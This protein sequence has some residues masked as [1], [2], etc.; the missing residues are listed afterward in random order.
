MKTLFIAVIGINLAYGQITGKI[1]TSK[2]EPVS[3]ANVI[4]FRAA[5]SSLVAGV[6]A[7]ESGVFSLTS[8]EVGRFFLKV[9]SI[10]FREFRSEVFH[11]SSLSEVL[12]LPPLFL[13]EENNTIDEVRVAAKRDFIQ[14]TPLGKIINIQS[15]LMT[16]GSNALQ[17]LERLPGVITDRRNNQF[18]LNGQSGVTVL[19]NGRRVQLSSEELMTLLE[20]TVADNIE[21]IELIT[22]PGAQYDADGGAG[23]INIIFKNNEVLGT[24]LRL[25]ATAGYGFRE[26]AVT[27]VGFSQR[28]K[29]WNLNASYSFNHDVR[30]SGYEGDGTAGSSFMLGETYNTFYGMSRSFQNTHNATVTLQYQPNSRTTLGGDVVSSFGQ[31]HNLVNNGGSYQPKNNDFFEIAM[32]SDGT[33]AKYNSI[34]SIYYRYTLAPKTQ[35]HADVTYINYANDSPAQITTAYFDKQKQPAA[36][37]FPIFTAGNR[38]ESKSNIHVGVFKTDLTLPLSAKVNA[39]FGV[40]MSYAQNAN[41]S[42]VERKTEDRWEID[43]RSQSRIQSRERIAA[44]YAQFRLQLNPKASLQAGVRYEYWQ[45]DFTDNKDRFRISKLF[46]SL[47]YTLTINESSTLSF[48]YNRRIS[49]PAYTDL[50][51]N[52]F[53]TDPTFIFSGNP[54]LKPTLTDVVKADYTTGGMN[55]GLS[56]QYDLHPILRYQITANET[57]DVGISSPQNLDEMKS[58]NLFLSYPLQIVKGWKVSLNTTTSFRH[59]R[60]SYS[61][62]PTEKQFLFQNLNFSQTLQFPRNFEAELSGWYNFPFF[63]GPNQLKGFGVVNLGIAKKLKN[64]KGT[65]QLALPDLLRSFSVFTHNGGMTPIAFDINTVSNWRDETVFYRVVKLTYSRTFGKNTRGVQYE[66]KDEERE[67]VR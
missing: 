19:F 55:I 36:P 56:W 11:I 31:S 25:S 9:S 53:Y 16:K 23:I 62:F 32:L 29:R 22:S 12:T 27:S 8:S 21:K 48:N 14:T 41:D 26:K 7:A 63:E 46:P 42:K 37:P 33:T 35:L 49:R 20:N 34:S 3:F 15:S 60:V 54:L 47:L 10:G 6:T 45:R 24:T 65:F 17:V 18:S 39:E 67:R 40:K 59:Y 50:I 64:D 57:K 13:S 58:V 44:T 61:Q 4:L 30:K 51:S 2:G 5:D 43:P 1:G 38:G 52:L 28:F 66:A